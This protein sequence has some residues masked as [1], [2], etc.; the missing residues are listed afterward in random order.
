[1]DILL[2]VKVHTIYNEN[3]YKELII[4]ELE[5]YNKYHEFPKELKDIRKITKVERRYERD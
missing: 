1:M 3:K 2:R 4:E 5:L